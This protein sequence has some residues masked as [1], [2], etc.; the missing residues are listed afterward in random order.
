MPAQR[1]PNSPDDARVLVPVKDFRQAKGRL[2]SVLDPEQRA[3]LA[4]ALATRVVAA[5]RPIGVWVICDDK[6]VA[7]WAESCHAEVLW[8]AGMGL[9]AAVT[10]G[11]EVARERGIDRAVVSHSDLPAAL[12]FSRLTES[13]GVEIV[14]DLRGE[15]TNVISLPTASG[16]K[17]SYGQG[18]CERHVAETKRL[19]LEVS[20][21]SDH[22][23][24]WD[25]DNPEDLLVPGAWGMDPAICSI[26]HLRQNEE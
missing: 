25:V 18:S 19:G 6:A 1:T 4:Q 8:C 15:G 2:S 26:P 5:A 22:R 10:H 21:L 16:F 7:Q 9:N 11:V 14:T 24:S 23:L 13:R 20:V 3:E 17:F 12:D